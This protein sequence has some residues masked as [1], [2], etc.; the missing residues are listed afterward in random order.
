MSNMSSVRRPLSGNDPVSQADFMPVTHTPKFIREWREAHPFRY[1]RANTVEE[2]SAS[3]GNGVLDLN[4]VLDDMPRGS[5]FIFQIKETQ[6]G[7][8]IQREIRCI[9]AWQTDHWKRV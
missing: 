9:Y 5:S 2:A 8:A 3:S 4:D 7:T 1:V 6:L